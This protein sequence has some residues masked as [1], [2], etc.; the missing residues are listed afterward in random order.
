MPEYIMKHVRLFDIIQ[1]CH[2]TQPAR[3]GEDAASQQSKECCSGY[4]ARYY[5]NLPAGSG[6]QLLVYNIEIRNGSR[7]KAHCI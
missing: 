2:S 5:G 4:Q 6:F 3:S 1:L 7:L